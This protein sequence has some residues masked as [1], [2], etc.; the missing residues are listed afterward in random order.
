MPRGGKFMKE[1]ISMLQSF[2]SLQEEIEKKYNDI[3]LEDMEKH[4]YIRICADCNTVIHRS[5]DASFKQT[6]SYLYKQ[7]ID[8]KPD[9]TEFINRY[10]HLIDEPS[11][12]HKE[13][14]GVVHAYRTLHQHEPSDAAYKKYKRICMDWTLGA[15]SKAEPSND[16]EW[17]ICEHY[18]LEN[19]IRYLKKAMCILKRF[20][21][22][23]RVLQE[24][25]FRYQKQDIT[26]L[27]AKDVLEQIKSDFEYEFDTEKF[28]HQCR[29][30]LKKSLQFLD[31]KSDG[32]D[33]QIYDCYCQVVFQMPVK[34]KILVQ[35]NEIKEK[36]GINDKRQLCQIMK[37]VSVFCQKTPK[38]NREEVWG[39]IDNIVLNLK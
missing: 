31:W 22:G 16:N 14:F 6:I 28:Y 39:L 23:G 32:I 27:S 29:G 3:R 13:F 2:I 19:G 35:P 30:N 18:L 26:L 12:F 38:C 21:C 5:P 34:R 36:Y 10:A 37:E 11:D 20:S 4:F 1:S 33:K 8:C 7:L 17:R 9:N 15:I 24:E 25:W